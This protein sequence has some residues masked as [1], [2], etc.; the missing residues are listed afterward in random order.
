MKLDAKKLLYE[1]AKKR[2][3]VSKLAEIAGITKASVSAMLHGR[4]TI[5]VDTLGKIADALGVEPADILT[6]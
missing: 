4:K 5:R 2:Y 1:M 6:D 3:T